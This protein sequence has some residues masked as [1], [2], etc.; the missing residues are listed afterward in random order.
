MI[1]IKEYRFKVDTVIRS[2]KKRFIS[3]VLPHKQFLAFALS[4]LGA[5][6]TEIPVKGKNGAPATLGTN[7][8]VLNDARLNRQL[9]MASS[10]AHA[11][12]SRLQSSAVAGWSRPISTDVR[13]SPSIRT[14]A[15]SPHSTILISIALF[16]GS[17]FIYCLSSSFS[18]EDYDSINFA[19]AVQNFDLTK[20]APHPPGAPIYIAFVKVLNVLINDIPLA[21]GI[22]AALGG[23]LFVTLWHKIFEWFLPQKTAAIATVILAVSPGLW[24]T[25]SRPMSDTMATAA[26][27]LSVLLALHY[28]KNR[29]LKFILWTSAVLAL[30]VGIRP[31]FGLLAPFLLFSTLFYF[32][33]NRNTSLKAVGIFTIVNLCWLVPT[34]VSQ[35]NLDGDGWM[36]YFN[37]IIRF[38]ENFDTASGSPL[39]ANNV[40]I[41]A[42]FYRAITHI[43]TLGYFALGLNIWY[44]ESVGAMLESFGTT[45]NP[46]HKED[47]EWTALGTLYTLAYVFGSMAIMPRIS[48]YWKKAQKISESIGYLILV[49]IAYSTVVIML[50][51]PHTRFYIALLPIFILLPLMGLQSRRWKHD[52][53]YGLMVLAILASGHTILDSVKQE[54]PPVALVKEIQLRTDAVGNNTVLLLNTNAARHAAWYLAQAKVYG[55]ATVPAPSDPHEV[56]ELNAKV[57]ANYSGAFPAEWVE[58]TLIEQYQRPYRVWMRHTSTPLYELTLRPVPL[59][60]KNNAEPAPIVE[61]TTEQSKPLQKAKAKTLEIATLIAP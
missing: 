45:L 14:L 20:D 55:S 38:K 53:Q 11:R 2:Y 1:V 43:G 56:F 54:A 17:F 44:P 36:T 37:Q 47:V 16:F 52:F 12:Y 27:S 28:G 19:L 13:T 9:D 5:K 46:W 31:Q 15:A 61:K 6:V 48:Y 23:A 40:S 50:V 57:F 7:S 32:R 41:S 42:I 60:A 8:R 51:P 33:P 21:L 24:M 29:E 22:S 58:E 35:Y 59:A 18:L 30:C 25:A 4:L 39:L 49:V 34:I 10:K 3:K 26:L